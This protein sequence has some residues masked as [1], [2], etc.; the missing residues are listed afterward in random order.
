[1]VS[2]G[3]ITHILF[4][5]NPTSGTL[6]INWVEAITLYFKDKEKYEFSIFLPDAL[7]EFAQLN[8]RIKL[9]NPQIVVAIGGDGTINWVART[10]YGSQIKLGIIPSGSANGLARN[11]NIP[12]DPKG[13]L[14]TLINGKVI[15][16]SSVSIGDRFCIH[17]SDI[18]LNAKLIRTFEHRGE[19]G[20]MS[21]FKAGLRVLRSYASSNVSIT[22]NGKTIETE[23]LMVVIANATM[24]GTGLIINPIGKLDDQLF[25]VIVIKKYSVLEI[26]K[27]AFNDWMPHPDKTE[28]IQCSEVLIEA[29]V[30]LHFQ[31]DGEYIGK[32]RSVS[33]SINNRMLQVIVP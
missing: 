1:M 18:G 31:V 30:P 20:L 4:V 11:L 29:A 5:I 22:A 17:L 3:A 12:L 8:E 25:E 6:S 23:A 16:M 24:Y 2:D 27:M 10:I 13:A 32:K 33:A 26:A 21:Y 19:R 28:V 9:L 7:S 14:D 15:P